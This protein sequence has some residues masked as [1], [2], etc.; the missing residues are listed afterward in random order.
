MRLS[1]GTH[2]DPLKLS[3]LVH[4]TV[5][6]P[7]PSISYL[8]FQRFAGCP[9]CNTTLRQFSL[10]VGE[11][12]AAGVQPIVFFHSEVETLDSYRKELPFIVVADPQR[13][14]YK[15][16]GVERSLLGAMHPMAMAAAMK[17]VFGGWAFFK[18][19]A[20]V[21]GLPADFLISAEGTVLA[22]KYGSHAADHWSTDEVLSLVRSQAN[23]ANKS[24]RA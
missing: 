5:S 14:Y 10:R 23:A 19:N 11:V 4:D 18:G 2:I 8:R 17:T 12:K 1:V 3:T 13:V 21:D 9:I 24:A 15:R 16:F 22:A 7:G 6:M 20:A